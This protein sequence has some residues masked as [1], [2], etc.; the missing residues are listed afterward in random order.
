MSVIW[1]DSNKKSQC[2]IVFCSFLQH[3]KLVN[4]FAFAAIYP[5]PVFELPLLVS[6]IVSASHCL[7]FVVVFI[8]VF[9]FQ[10][11]TLS[12]LSFSILHCSTVFSGIRF[13]IDL[14]FQSFP[15]LHKTECQLDV[16]GRC[17][18]H[19]LP[20]ISFFIIFFLFT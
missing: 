20:C 19:V 2:S 12:F 13:L 14:L 7:Y 3:F 6:V 1:L 16:I 9:A 4:I 10:S 11:F 17:L 8:F 5:Q 15:N 18:N